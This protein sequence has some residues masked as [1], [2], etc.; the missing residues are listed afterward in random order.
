[1]GNGRQHEKG[2]RRKKFNI[3]LGAMKYMPVTLIITR[4]DITPE[5]GK[6]I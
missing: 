3:V 2:K 1:M 5:L 6:F 4:L